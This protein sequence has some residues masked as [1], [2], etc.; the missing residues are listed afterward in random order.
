MIV[1]MYIS[2]VCIL[3][4][5]ILCISQV[6]LVVVAFLYRKRPVCPKTKFR[7]NRI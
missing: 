1:Y 2:D 3:K 6:V 4:N 5:L 7:S